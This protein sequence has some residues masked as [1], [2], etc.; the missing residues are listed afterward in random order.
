VNID[1]V[2]TLIVITHVLELFGLN[3]PK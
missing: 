2:A 3:S 1:T